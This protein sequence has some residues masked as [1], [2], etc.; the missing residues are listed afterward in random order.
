MAK[1]SRKQQLPQQ[2]QEDEEIQV[3]EEEEE[4][5]LPVEQIDSQEEEEEDQFELIGANT[6]RK[7]MFIMLKDHVAKV[8]NMSSAKPGKHGHAKMIISAKDPFTR[9]KVEDSIPTQGRIEAPVLKKLELRV[10]SLDVGECLA[11]LWDPKTG[12]KFPKVKYDDEDD[13][14]AKMTTQAHILVLAIKFKGKIAITGVK[15]LKK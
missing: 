4:E 12:A 9:K 14:V 2:E 8:M 13:F 1:K 5:Q 11:N 10:E 6:V 15:E 3:V 7:G